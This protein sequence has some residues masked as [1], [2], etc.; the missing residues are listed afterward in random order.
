METTIFNPG[1]AELKVMAKKYEDLSIKGV[2]DVVGYTDVKA[3]RKELGSVRNEITKAGKKAREEYIAKQKSVIKQEKEYLEIIVPLEDKFKEMLTEVDE[4][5]K[6]KEREALLPT[7]KKMLSE[8]NFKAFTDNSLL[9]MD[10]SEFSQFYMDKKMDYDKE[11]EYKKQ[12]EEERKKREKEEKEREEQFEAQRKLDA[13]EAKKRAEEDKALALEKAVEEEKERQER[14]KEEEI[15][16]L[17]RQQQEEIDKIKRQQ[18]EERATAQRKKMEAEAIARSE[19]EKKEKLEKMKK[20][21]KFLADNGCNYSPEI[22]PVEEFDNEDL[23]EDFI[24]VKFKGTFVLYKQ[25]DT[26][27]IK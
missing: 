12:Q 24:V 8:I 5:K 1:I 11:V 4:A 18:E 26:I 14:K 2:D 13:I 17:K 25:I 3:A 23:V 7:R 9:D 20:Y 10:D 27:T 6:R 15:N 19:Q 16:R 22:I 21:K